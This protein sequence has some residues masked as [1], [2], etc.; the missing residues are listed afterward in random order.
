MKN[1]QIFGILAVLVMSTFSVTANAETSSAKPLFSKWPYVTRIV[2]AEQE[3]NSKM[4]CCKKAKE[5][6]PE[7]DCCK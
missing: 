5:A 2:R 3:S 7:M 4:E 6:C 1:S